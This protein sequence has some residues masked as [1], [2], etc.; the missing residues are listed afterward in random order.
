MTCS[1]LPGYL[2][3]AASEAFVAAVPL[4]AVPMPGAPAGAWPAAGA[5]AAADEDAAAVVE[6]VSLEDPQAV[7][8]A[9]ESS[10]AEPMMAMRRLIMRAGSARSMGAAW[11][12]AGGSLRPTPGPGASRAS[13]RRP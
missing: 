4:T 3:V 9:I 10:P 12:A 6:V 8:P 5:E 1:T 2:A 11:G 13:R 7:R